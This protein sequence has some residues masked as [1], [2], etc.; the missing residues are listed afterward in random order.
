MKRIVAVFAVIFGIL[1]S[2]GCERFEKEYDGR[3][4][5][6]ENTVDTGKEKST[7]VS[8]GTV[9]GAEAAGLVKLTQG[10]FSEYGKQKNYYNINY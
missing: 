9:K 10:S 3:Y 7:V 5:N 6:G 2:L 1:T 8:I 4:Y